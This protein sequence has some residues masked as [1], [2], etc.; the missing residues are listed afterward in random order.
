MSNSDFNPDPPL[1]SSQMEAMEGFY[2]NKRGKKADD[3][4]WGDLD[5]LPEPTREEK[6]KGFMDTLGYTRE[7]A[8]RLFPL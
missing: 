3:K 5:D 2:I 1:H 4:F 6:I 8:E 7:Q